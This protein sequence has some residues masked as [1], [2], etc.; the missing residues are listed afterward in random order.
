MKTHIRTLWAGGKFPLWDNAEQREAL[1]LY[2]NDQGFY[3][4]TGIDDS[5]DVHAIDY[6]EAWDIRL[7]KKGLDKI[8]KSWYTLLRK[9][10]ED[11]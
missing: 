1:R 6:T 5:L 9:Q 2:L 4:L 7:L 10:K 11:I 3:V 8:Q